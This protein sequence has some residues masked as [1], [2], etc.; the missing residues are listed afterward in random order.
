MEKPKLWLRCND[1]GLHLRCPQK[2]ISLPSHYRSTGKSECPGSSFTMLEYLDPEDARRADRERERR[3]KKYALDHPPKKRRK[4][5]EK[6]KSSSPWDGV[7]ATTARPSKGSAGAPT[8]GK[9][10]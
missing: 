9:R 10:K 3:A 8:L 6:I 1:C 4:P 2:T 7:R 5:G